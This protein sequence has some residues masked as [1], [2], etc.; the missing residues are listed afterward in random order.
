MEKFSGYSL[1]SN[2]CRNSNKKHH[3]LNEVYNYLR[4]VLEQTDRLMFEE[5]LAELRSRLSASSITESFGDYFKKEWVNKKTQW[6]YAYRVSMG[7][8]TNMY[9]E[10]FHRVFKY[11]YLKGKVNKRV[12]KCLV[13]L[14]K[15][16][17]DQIFSRL[18]KLTKGKNSSR[19]KRI[20]ESHVRSK[21]M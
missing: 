5:Y 14:I 16:S 8:N 9:C 6:G 19:I 11:K 13:S 21:N 7:I 3:I 2:P 15:Y 1:K 20:Q 4:I 12:D 17:R 10:A 18:C